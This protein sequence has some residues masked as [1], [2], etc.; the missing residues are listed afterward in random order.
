[1]TL[2]PELWSKAIVSAFKEN[3]MA[4]TTWGGATPVNM[5]HNPATM[6]TEVMGLDV[7]DIKEL[8]ILLQ[9]KGIDIKEVLTALEDM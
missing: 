6:R 8:S 3:L 2:V 9:E 4:T 7:E 5:F 1:M